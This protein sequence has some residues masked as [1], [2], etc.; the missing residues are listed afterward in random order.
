MKTIL[1][2]NK[3]L[4]NS[5]CILIATCTNDLVINAK[6]VN[7]FEMFLLSFTIECRNVL[8]GEQKVIIERVKADFIKLS[9][10]FTKSFNQLLPV[11]N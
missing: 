11:S 5:F 9:N 2:F 3:I 1:L 10:V 7:Y 6:Q 4:T 8:F